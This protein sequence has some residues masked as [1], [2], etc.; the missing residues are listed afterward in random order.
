MEGDCF[1]RRR[2]VSGELDHVT[3]ILE[4]E[5]LAKATGDTCGLRY[6][7]SVPLWLGDRTLGVMNLVGPEKGLFTEDELKVLYGVGNQVAV[8]LDRA[9]LHANLERLVE[10]RTA[11]LAAE[12]EERKRIEKEQAR[13]VAIIEATPDLVATVGLD[14]FPLYFNHAGLRMIGYEDDAVLPS[15]HIRETHSEWAGKLVEEEGIPHAIEH[16]SW[17]GETALL[18]PNGREMP[19]S[20]VIIS[21]KGDKGSV[22]Y[23]S[24]IMRDI[25]VQKENERR[26]VRLNRLYSIL[27]GI[28]T[29]IVRVHDSDELFGEACRIAVD[30]GKFRM[31]WI[32]TV[33]RN[34]L[35]IVPVA[36]ASAEPEFLSTIKDRF[37]LDKDAPLG[38]TLTARAVREK[39]TFLS[40]DL[41]GDQTV[42]FWERHVS[43]GIHSMA[44]LPMLVGDEAVGVLA[45]Y[46]NEIGFF[47]EEELK[48]LTELA[49]DI[50]FAIDHI[51]KEHRLNYLA[52]YDVLT[53]LPNRTLLYDRLDQGEKAARRNEWMLAVLFVDLDNFKTIND[54]HGHMS[55]D[56]V[57]RTVARRFERALSP[58][59]SR[60]SRRNCTVR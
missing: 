15:M 34:A 55:G 33:S 46:A 35:N 5:R 45:L 39:K 25:S 44:I 12:I 40:N 58:A 49:G 51:E 37:S 53:G 6:H 27:S 36:S 30:V 11:K 22:E 43:R 16:G 21:H 32:G 18:Q 47:D 23:L 7:A 14:G 56:D 2:L 1:C 26:I 24:T 52:Y 54:S 13:L 41:Q 48:L 10:E 57:L 3:N 20:Q 17:T 59:S 8:A 19:V 31:A 38:N 9:R 4:C 29:L 42:R 60:C 28:N 50:A